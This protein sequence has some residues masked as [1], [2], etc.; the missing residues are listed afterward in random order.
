MEKLICVKDTPLKGMGIFA[1][2]DIR[3]DEEI[4]FD[5]SMIMADLNDTI[6]QRSCYWLFRLNQRHEVFLF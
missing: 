6:R 3:K 1:L 4:T 5:Y 2:R